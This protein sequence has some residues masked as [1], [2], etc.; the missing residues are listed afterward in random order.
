MY[1]C[2][3]YTYTDKENTTYDLSCANG[4]VRLIGG[5]NQ[6]E[7]RVEMCYNRFWGPVCHGSW[8]ITDANVVCG[9]LG[10]QNKGTVSNLVIFMII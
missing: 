10:Y 1:Y 8:S 6:A 2:S 7:G 4:D 3:I 5:I 9:Q